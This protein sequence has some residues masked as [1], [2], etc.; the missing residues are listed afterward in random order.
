MAIHYSQPKGFVGRNLCYAILFSGIY[1][2]H[3]VGGSSTLHLP[4]RHEVL[5]TT[6][7]DLNS[8]VNNIFFHAFKVEEKYPVRNFTAKI[9][10]EYRAVIERDWPLQYGDRV[11]GHETL[12]ELPRSG[13]CYLRDGWTEV[14]LTKGQTCKRVAGP[15]KER[16]S[17]VRVWDRVNLRPKRVFVRPAERHTNSHTKIG[18][19]IAE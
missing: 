2:G 1:Y 14:G 18:P 10:R 11:I 9:L 7:A 19:P 17:G 8:I 12:V 15:K 5:R 3:I 13:E 4:G 16:W 6:Q